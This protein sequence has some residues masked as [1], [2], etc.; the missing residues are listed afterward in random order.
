MTALRTIKFRSKNARGERTQ[1]RG[2]RKISDR[3]RFLGACRCEAV[4]RPPVWLM[5]QAGRVLP[6][7]RLLKQKHSFLELVQTPELAAEVTVQPVRRFGFDAA[8][9][10]SDILVIPEALGQPYRFPDRGGIVMD[11][12]IRS[13]ADIERLEK[14]GGP[15][16]PRGHRAALRRAGPRAAGLCGPSASPGPQGSR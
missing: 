9:L 4:D 10:F 5:R 1:G 3:D 6:E 15:G 7:Y 16:S 8:I 12:A 2:G 14:W 11:F 13:R